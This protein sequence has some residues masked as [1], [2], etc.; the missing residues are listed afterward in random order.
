M[1]LAKG[2]SSMGYCPANGVVEI[3]E[4]ISYIRDFGEMG[5]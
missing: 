3:F 1:R 5:Y 2:I 4:R